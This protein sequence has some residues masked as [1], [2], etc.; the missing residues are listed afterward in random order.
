MRLTRKVV[1]SRHLAAGT[2]K[3]HTGH[4]H[5]LVELAEE[6]PLDK[7]RFADSHP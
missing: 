1:H 5:L 7:V 4:H 6:P 3:E 2:E